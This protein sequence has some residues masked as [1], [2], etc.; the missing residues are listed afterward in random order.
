MASLQTLQL[1]LARPLSLLET[2]WLERLRRRRADGLDAQLQRRHE[3]LAHKARR[4]GPQAVRVQANGVEGAGGEAR[5]IDASGPGR[6]GAIQGAG[7]AS[8]SYTHLYMVPS[9][10]RLPPPP[11][12]VWSR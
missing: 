12:M 6:G 9:S 1:S 7:H 3:D 5:A 10:G 2:K 8:A 11:P 4:Q